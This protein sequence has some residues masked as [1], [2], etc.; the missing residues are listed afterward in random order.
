V[1]GVAGGAIRGE[2]DVVV[3]VRASMAGTAGER[4]RE[5]ERLTGDSGNCFGWLRVETIAGGGERVLEMIASG[6]SKRE[7]W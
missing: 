3:E 1:A 6:W 2:A 5:V 7:V 4:E